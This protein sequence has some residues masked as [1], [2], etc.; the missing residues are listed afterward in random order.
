MGC[1]RE[2]ACIGEK[3]AAA[4]NLPSLLPSPPHTFQHPHTRAHAHTHTPWRQVRSCTLDTWLP[5]QVQFIAW[6]GGNRRANDYWEAAL[7]GGPGAREGLNLGTLTGGYGM[8]VRQETVPRCR[9][10]ARLFLGVCTCLWGPHMRPHTHTHTHA[11]T[12]THTAELES[13][14]RRKYSGREYARGVWPPPRYEDDIIRGVLAEV[15]AAG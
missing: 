8:G 13:F 2:L 12:R 10:S 11:C 1:C 6:V 4:R 3:K 14:I 7:P 9:C 5:S 15:A